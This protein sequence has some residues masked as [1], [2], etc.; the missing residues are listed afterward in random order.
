M[1]R[2]APHSTLEQV[3]KAHVRPH[4]EYC[5][6]IFHQPPADGPLSTSINN[7][8]TNMHKLES[9]QIQAAYAVSGAWKG[10]STIKIYK[11]LG[12]EWLT[13]RR[14]YRRMNLF[15]KIVNKLT[16]SFL[17]DCISYPDPPWISAYGRQPP[18]PNP[19]II[20]P[21]T[22]RTIN[23]QSSFFPSSVFSWNRILTS[24]QRNAKNLKKFKKKLLSSFK[25][26]KSNNYGIT[27]KR[28][29]RILTQLRVDLNPLRFYKFA[30]KFPD[31]SNELCL[32]VLGAEDIYHYLLHCHVFYGIRNTLLINVSGIVGEDASL[33]SDTT[34]KD[35]L[36]YGDEN[37]SYVANKSILQETLKFIHQSERFQRF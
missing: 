36:L 35:L 24:D 32:C 23:V 28:G 30:Y 16:P 21:F 3:Y 8:S 29:L 4:L 7:L 15:Y 25:P 5:D 12:W 6:V 2:Y 17:T 9:V 20:T 31:T 13:Q 27:D 10:T 33:Y 1:S 26:V 18:N 14:W 22:P 11:E 34:L 37:L 19:F